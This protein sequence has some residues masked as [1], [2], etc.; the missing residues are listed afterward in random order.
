MD[1]RIHGYVRVSTKEQNEERQVNEL[2]DEGILYRDIYIDKINGN[3][4]DRPELERLL[5]VV[6]KGDLIVVTSID[7]LGRNYDLIQEIWKYI[8]KKLEVDI[9]VLDMP[10]LDTSANKDNLDSRFISDLTLQI[11]SYVAQKERISIKARQ[12]QGIANARLKGRKL[13][14][15]NA[16]FPENWNVVYREWRNGRITANEAMKRLDLKRN[17]FYKLVKR[18]EI[19]LTIDE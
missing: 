4:N 17:T 10:L 7:R 9:K 2:R 12:A 18:Y 19:T 13:G 11:L 8:T 14:R 6:R 15:P 1:R 5:N 3:T 16:K